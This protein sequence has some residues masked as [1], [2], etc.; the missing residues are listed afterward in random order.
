[1]CKLLIFK[2]ISLHVLPRCYL[3]ELVS[4][5]FE[6]EPSLEIVT[7]IYIEAQFSRSKKELKKSQIIESL[8]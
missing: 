6:I 2:L 4:K 7:L 5:I 3:L 8:F 1:M